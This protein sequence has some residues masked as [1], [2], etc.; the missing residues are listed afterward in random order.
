M[1]EFLQN[2]LAFSS[3]Q[4]LVYCH[5]SLVEEQLFFGLFLVKKANSSVAEENQALPIL[6]LEGRLQ[7]SI[8]MVS[9]GNHFEIN[10]VLGTS[11]KVLER[12]NMQN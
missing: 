9:K 2:V 3:K 5:H 6:V 12:Q 1:V 7:K 8:I 10:L 11:F 4:D